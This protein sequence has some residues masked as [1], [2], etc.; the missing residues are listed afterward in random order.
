MGSGVDLWFRFTFPFFVLIHPLLFARRPC[1]RGTKWGRVRPILHARSCG[2]GGGNGREDGDYHVEDLTPESV[3]V[4][5]SHSD[6]LVI[7]N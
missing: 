1:L 7:S 4:E 5:R 6:G 3:V 2:E